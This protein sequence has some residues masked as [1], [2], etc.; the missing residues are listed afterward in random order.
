MFIKFIH[1]FVSKYSLIVWFAHRA[2]P[3]FVQ[4]GSL[5]GKCPLGMKWRRRRDIGTHT[6]RCWRQNGQS[7][8]WKQKTI[9]PSILALKIG[10]IESTIGTEA[11]S[12]YII[13]FVIAICIQFLVIFLFQWFALHCIKFRKSFRKYKIE[14][15]DCDRRSLW[16]LGRLEG[17]RLARPI[18][19]YRLL[20]D[21]GHRCKLTTSHRG[22]NGGRRCCGRRSELPK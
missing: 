10:F 16:K 4:G 5:T 21:S 9:S 7:R 15:S 13:K 6:Q 14:R 12:S 11:R 1:L 22:V 19:S 18:R 3:M 17:K 8:M 2:R 20:R